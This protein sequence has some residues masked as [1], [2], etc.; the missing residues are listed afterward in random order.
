MNFDT[1]DLEI[2]KLVEDEN[3]ILNNIITLKSAFSI[4]DEMFMNLPVG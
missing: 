3:S 4:I 2:E 1:Y